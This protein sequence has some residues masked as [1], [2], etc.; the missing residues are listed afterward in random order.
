MTSLKTF[1]LVFILIAM[2]AADLFGGWA[3][4]EHAVTHQTSMLVWGGLSF[5]I[6]LALAAYALWI[7]HTLERAHV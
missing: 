5:V 2:M 4:H 1:H 3:I 6:G 7:V